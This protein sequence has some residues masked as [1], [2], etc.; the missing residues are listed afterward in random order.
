VVSGV[1]AAAD[2]VEGAPDQRVEVIDLGA[3]VTGAVLDRG[4]RIAADRFG[5]QSPRLSL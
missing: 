5:A 1:R 4:D 2:R 3:E